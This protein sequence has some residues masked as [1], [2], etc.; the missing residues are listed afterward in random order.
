MWLHVW[1]VCSFS[2]LTG[3]PPG[4]SD[5]EV[6]DCN[7]G[8]LGSIPGSGRPLGEGNGKPLQYSYLQSF[9]GRGVGR[10]P[11]HRVAKSQM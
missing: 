9:M 2:L 7:A 6:S 3:G 11:V 4:D 8:D 1:E 5:D 10:A